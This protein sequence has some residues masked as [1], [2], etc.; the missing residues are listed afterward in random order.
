M[1]PEERNHLNEAYLK[2]QTILEYGSGIST[3]FAATLP[4]KTV[5]SIESD[6]AWCE[7]LRHRLPAPADGTHVHLRHVDI[8][9]TGEW[10]RP[11]GTKHWSEFHTYPLSIWQEPGFQQPDLVLIDGR[12]R[13]ACFAATCIFA[14]KPI[15]L[16]FD[17]YYPRPRYHCVEEMFH[18]VQRIGRMAEFH[19]QPRAYTPLEIAKFITFFSMAS[20]APA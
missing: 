16:L 2:A 8:G 20:Y 14:E 7:A 9:P 3:E 5:F 11:T 15:K 17:D 6:S 18:P 1:P 4:G 12:F 10:G 13:V 19:I